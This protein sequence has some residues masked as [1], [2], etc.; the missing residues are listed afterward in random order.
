M[1]PVF[2]LSRAPPSHPWLVMGC[3][4]SRHIATRSPPCYLASG[5]DSPPSPA[6][7]RPDLST[8]L[9]LQWRRVGLTLAGR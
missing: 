7:P 8:S 4:G 2:Q 5:T 9:G 6:E 1:L 3:H